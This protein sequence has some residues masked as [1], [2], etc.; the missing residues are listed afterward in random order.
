M[1]SMPA[2][3]VSTSNFPDFLPPP[4]LSHGSNPPVKQSGQL[5]TRQAFIYQPSMNAVCLDSTH[6]LQTKDLKN[7]NPS[8]IP[9]GCNKEEPAG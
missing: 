2:S 7:S 8:K 6:G 1:C 9:F 5:V 4:H 3:P